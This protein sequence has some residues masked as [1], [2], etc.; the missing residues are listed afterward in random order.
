MSADLCRFGQWC[1]TRDTHGNPGQAEARGLCWPDETHGRYAISQLADDY[2]GLASILGKGIAPAGGG[3]ASGPPG[4]RLPIREHVDALMRQIRWALETWEVAVRERARLSDVPE[5]GVR[6][7]VVVERAAGILTEHYSVLLALGAT[8][9]LDYETAAAV[10]AD[11]PGAVVELT[12]LHHRA[13]SMLGL[14]RRR[15]ARAL[16]CPL[17]PCT[18]HGATPCRDPRCA[19]HVTGCGLTE[20]GQD[21]GGNVVDCRSCGWS[22]SLD[23]YA[24]YAISLQVPRRAA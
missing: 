6:D 17:I 13:R 21:I 5:H 24:A 7:W 19:E 9:I 18:R 10:D 1:A 16:P 11:G 23:E 4:P 2:A 8:D 12:Q 22:C 15:E 3:G 14:T 20:L